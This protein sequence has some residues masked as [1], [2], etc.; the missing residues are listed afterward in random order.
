LI[1]NGRNKTTVFDSN[2]FSEALS[3]RISLDAPSPLSPPLKG[4]GTFIHVL[5]KEGKR[6]SPHTCSEK[7]G[8]LLAGLSKNER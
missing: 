2:V 7:K 1:R 5:L 3:S 6:I 4:G 8:R